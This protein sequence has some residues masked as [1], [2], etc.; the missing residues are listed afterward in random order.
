MYKRGDSWVSDFWH[1]GK[2]YKKSWADISKTVAGE[3]EGQFKRDV[4]EGRYQAR[5]SRIR[6][7]E[8]AEEYMKHAKLHK[9]PSL[10]NETRR[11]LT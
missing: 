4:K 7:E 9:S 6:F 3:K 2:R 10:Q 1:D 8:F 5:A 11:P